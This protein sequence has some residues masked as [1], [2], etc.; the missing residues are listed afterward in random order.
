[1]SDQLGNPEVQLDVPDLTTDIA[2]LQKMNEGHNALLRGHGSAS[3]ATR[4]PGSIPRDH[5]KAA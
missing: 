3:S 4:L 5:S 1:M 2:I